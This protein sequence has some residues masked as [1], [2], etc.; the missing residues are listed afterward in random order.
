MIS[1]S[2]VFD[3]GRHNFAALDDR[4]HLLGD[5]LLLVIAF[6]GTGQADIDRTGLTGNNLDRVDT[7]FRQVNLTRIGVVDLDS[8]DLS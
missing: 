8:R 5:R 3:D 2:A 7:L 4:L 6:L 1:L